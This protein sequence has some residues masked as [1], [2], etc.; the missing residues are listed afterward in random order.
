MSL[1]L[2]AR[3]GFHE[4]KWLRKAY[5]MTVEE[6]D[7]LLASQGGRC[8]ICGAYDVEVWHVDHCH[9]SGTVRGMLCPPCNLGLG[10]FHDDPARLKAAIIYLTR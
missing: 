7:T 3:P 5:G 4:A 2:A 1:F 9:D 8:A 10:H 6:R